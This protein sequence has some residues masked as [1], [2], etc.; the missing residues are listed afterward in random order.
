[1]TPR[2]KKKHAG[3]RPPIMTPE[4]VKKLEECFS[5]SLTDEEACL[6]ADI[7]KPTLYAYCEAHPEF[8]DRKELLKK[9]PS[10]K[11]KLNRVNA[12]NKG[13]QFASA[14]WLERKSRDEFSTKSFTETK[15]VT[16]HS[17]KNVPTSELEAMLKEAMEADNEKP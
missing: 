2:V 15:A 17:L 9:R 4:L 13:D 7:S 5:N 8:S 12:I 3:G 14:W 16:F 6:I 11:A 1:M 10:I